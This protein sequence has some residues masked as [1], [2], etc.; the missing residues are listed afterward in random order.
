MKT[1]GILFCLIAFGDPSYAS[2]TSVSS[3]KDL[4]ATLIDVRSLVTNLGN[5]AFNN[6]YD[7][8]LPVIKYLKKNCKAQKSSYVKEEF[9]ENSSKIL[10]DFCSIAY[11]SHG[12]GK[13]TIPTDKSWS[14]EYEWVKSKDPK[15]VFYYNSFGQINSSKGKKTDDGYFIET[16]KTQFQFE[17]SSLG[18]YQGTETQIITYCK[19]AESFYIVKYEAEQFISSVNSRDH[20]ILTQ[21]CDSR[22]SGKCSDQRITFNGQPISSW[23]AWMYAD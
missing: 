4:E 8:T 3:S 12:K 11:E 16:K 22:C 1:L 21:E 7:S 14:R 17:H 13:F 18:K 9:Y 2:Q 15:S 6:W 20:I 10:G 5:F 23:Y 19:K